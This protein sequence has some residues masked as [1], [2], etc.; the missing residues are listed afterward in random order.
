MS[1]WFCTPSTALLRKYKGESF[2]KRIRKKSERAKWLE[3]DCLIFSTGG[4]TAYVRDDVRE[5]PQ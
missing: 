4:S 3:Q 2:A 5:P 1:S